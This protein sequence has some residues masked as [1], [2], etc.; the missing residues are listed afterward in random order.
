[1]TLKVFAYAGLMVS[2]GRTQ[3]SVKDNNGRFRLRKIDG[4]MNFTS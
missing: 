2:S 1:M 4:R 3:R